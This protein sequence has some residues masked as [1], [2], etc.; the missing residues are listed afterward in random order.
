MAIPL[1]FLRE[2]YETLASEIARLQ[3]TTNPSIHERISLRLFL[4]MLGQILVVAPVC[5]GAVGIGST[6]TV[7]ATV[8]RRAYNRDKRA[9]E[10]VPL[11]GLDQKPHTVIEEVRIGSYFPFGPNGVTS[12]DSFVGRALLG[13]RVGETREWEVGGGQVIRYA[14]LAIE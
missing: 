12:Y 2:D 8:M 5:D 11:L 13:A 10:L 6:V 1:K 3:Q 4:Q 14:V 9:Y 7:R